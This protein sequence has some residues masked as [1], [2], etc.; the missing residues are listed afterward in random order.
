MGSITLSADGGMPLAP[1]DPRSRRKRLG[2]IAALVAVAIA[3]VIVQRVIWPAG[4]SA[5]Y[6]ASALKAHVQIQIVAPAHAQEV[7]NELAGPGRLNAVG[8]GATGGQQVPQEIVGHLSFRT[9]HNAPSDGQYALFVI[10]KRVGA[11]LSQLYGVGPV[12]SNVGQGWDGAYN[13]IAAK[14]PWLR[15]LASV[16]SD[17]GV[18]DPGMAVSFRPNTRGPITFDAILNPNSHPITNASQQLTIA[19]VFVGENGTIY[20]AAKLSG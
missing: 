9:P 10:D 19:L 14:Y 6:P 12:G 16:A 3:A 4:S 17:D 18:T 11:P 5:P 8:A 7:I 20:W 15:M 13:Q 1:I 2:L